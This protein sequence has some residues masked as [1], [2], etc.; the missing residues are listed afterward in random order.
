MAVFT[1]HE[2]EEGDKI[3][4]NIYSNFHSSVSGTFSAEGHKEYKKKK[5][6]RYYG[7]VI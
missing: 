7:L 1:I 6:F 3:P 4:G 5:N 2:L